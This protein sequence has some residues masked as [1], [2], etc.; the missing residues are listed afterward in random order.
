M[1]EHI[2]LR[3]TGG[4]WVVRAK[5]AVLAESK[6]ALEMHEGDYAPVIYFPREDVGM[7]FLEKTSSSTTCPHKGVASYYAI[8]EK[9]AR[10]PMRHG[11]TRPRSKVWKRL[12]ATLGFMAIKSPWKS[13]DQLNPCPAG[14]Q[15]FVL[16]MFF[17]GGLRQSPVEG[18]QGIDVV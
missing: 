15:A 3:P 10:S 8:L 16:G 1:A 18:F 17:L 5:G 9:A 13:F 2:K 14:E 6:N 4:T 7:E 11:P 12:P